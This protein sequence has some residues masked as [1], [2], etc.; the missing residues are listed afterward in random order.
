MRPPKYETKPYGN[1]SPVSR[2]NVTIFIYFF[3]NIYFDQVVAM[4]PITRGPF[5]HLK[6]DPRD[7]SCSKFYICFTFDFIENLVLLQV[8][9][10]VDWSTPPVDQN[11]TIRI[12]IVSND[13]F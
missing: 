2:D 5:F 12:E 3:I 8:H 7:H 1:H 13:Y 10:L 11:G 4:K 6:F 9:W